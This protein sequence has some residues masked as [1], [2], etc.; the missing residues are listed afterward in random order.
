MTE[1]HRR[2]LP[3]FVIATADQELAAVNELLSALID[4]WRA[5]QPAYDAENFDHM[6]RVCCFMVG[7]VLPAAAPKGILAALAAAVVRLSYL[8]ES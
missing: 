7:D 8:E 1:F 2:P 6:E 3:P 5:R 4:T